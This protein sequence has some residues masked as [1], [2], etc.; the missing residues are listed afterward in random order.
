ME[1]SS[2][3]ICT[4]AKEAMHN[5]EICKENGLWGIPSGSRNI[6]MEKLKKGDTFLVYRSSHGFIAKGKFLSNL[7]KPK[8]KEEAPWAGGLFRYGAVADIEVEKEIIP[9]FK[10]N[11]VNQR[12]IDTS[13]SATMLRNGLCKI[14]EADA[15]TI[16][17]NY[18]K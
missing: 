9:L 4:V 12:M 16:L 18:F 10:P 1:E 13:V 17:K 6:N 15:R 7:R 5:W 11:F 8:S 2:W 3:L 14:S